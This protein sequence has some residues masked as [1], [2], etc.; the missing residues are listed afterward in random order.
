M[1]RKP[2]T[3]THRAV[4]VMVRYTLEEYEAIVEAAKGEQIAVHVRRVSLAGGAEPDPDPRVVEVH[5]RS[6]CGRFDMRIGVF[7]MTRALGMKVRHEAQGWTVTLSA[8]AEHP[9]AGGDLPDPQA[10]I[11]GLTI[12]E[13]TAARLRDEGRRAPKT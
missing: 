9:K 10:Q 7:T 5:A 2:K 8:V 13:I 11:A 12:E 3:A 6:K 1:N 4:T